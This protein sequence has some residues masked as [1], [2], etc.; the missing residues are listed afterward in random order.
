M[1][2][3]LTGETVETESISVRN[4]MLA[5]FN[6]S[7]ATIVAK[8]IDYE[9]A[10]K[11]FVDGAKWNIVEGGETYTEWEEYTK[12]GPI[13]DNRDGT[14]TIKMGMADT[15]EQVALREAK[16]AKEI[17]TMTVGKSITSVSEADGV[18]AEIESVFAAATLTDDEKIRASY[19]CQ[20][21]VSGNHTVGET[22]N[23]DGQTW[24]CYQAYDNDIYPDIKPG[25]T[26]W[27]TFNRPLHG[28]SQATARPFVPVQGAH[29]MY[30]TGEYAIW[31]DGKTYRCKQDTAYSPA[32]QPDAWEVVE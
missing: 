4:E 23:A 26:A 18:R 27:Y 22:Y 21:W 6:R 32:D 8:G 13:T 29:D 11:L 20:D 30:H 1:I 25:N 9:K 16:E 10:L 19:M 3:F 24:E 17:V 28:K 7:T 12:A 2:K 14:M 15:S 31:T 5:G